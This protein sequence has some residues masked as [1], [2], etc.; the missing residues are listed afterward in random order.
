MLWVLT[1]L[2]KLAVACGWKTAN[3]YN[4]KPLYF[5]CDFIFIFEY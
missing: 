1:K 4:Q 3:E 2:N 5:Q